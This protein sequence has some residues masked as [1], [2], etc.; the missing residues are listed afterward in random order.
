MTTNKAAF[1]EN[2]KANGKLYVEQ[3]FELYSTQ[4][5]EAWKQLYHRMLPRWEKYANE[6]FMAGS[7]HVGTS[8]PGGPSDGRQRRVSGVRR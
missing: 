6:H 7:H 3:P 1:I 2:A 4:N 8:L 5:H